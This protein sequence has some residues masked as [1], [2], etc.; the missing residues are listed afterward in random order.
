MKLLTL[1]TALVVGLVPAADAVAA[2]TSEWAGIV[3]ESVTIPMEGGWSARA[4]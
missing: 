2:N 1:A 4:S 3:R